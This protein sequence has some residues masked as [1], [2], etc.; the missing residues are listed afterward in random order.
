LHHIGAGWQR[1]GQGEGEVAADRID[2]RHQQTGD[3]VFAA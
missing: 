2:A 1:R 3:G